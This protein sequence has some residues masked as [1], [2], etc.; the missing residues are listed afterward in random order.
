MLSPFHHELPM[1]VTRA[2]DYGIRALV[3]MA[4]HPEGTRFYLHDLSKQAGLP[5]NYLVKVLK[6]LAG[7]SIVCSFRGIKGGFSLGRKPEEISLRDVIEAI[8]GPIAIISCL[9]EPSTNGCRHKGHCAAH[10]RL[11][12]IREGVLRQLDAC[13]IEDL[14]NE[15]AAMD[16]RTI[17]RTVARSY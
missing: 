8:D 13:S 5:R 16:Q 17:A 10:R 6:S 2:V 14:K 15:Q 9:N 12:V 7:N 11:G 1:E 4:R 3:L